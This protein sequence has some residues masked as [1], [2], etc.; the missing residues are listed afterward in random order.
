MKNKRK[1]YE[2]WRKTK[3]QKLPEGDPSL[4]KTFTDYRRNLK[5]IIERAKSSYYCTKINEHEGD[6]KKTWSIINELRGKQKTTIK[7][8]FVIDN[9]RIIERRI[10]ANKFNDYFVNIATKMNDEA[11]NSNKPRDSNSSTEYEKYTHKS[12]ENSIYLR[13]CTAD[14]IRLIISEFD[15]GKASDIPI[16]VIKATSPIISPILENVYNCLMQAGKFPDELKIGKISQTR[17]N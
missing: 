14:E 2:K 1:L 15:N 16:R 8:Q 10:I 17:A 12:S 11:Y 7:P 13:D 3:S 5:H 6:M 9:Q 4:H